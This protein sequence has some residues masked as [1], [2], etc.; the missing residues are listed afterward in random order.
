[1]KKRIIIIAICCIFLVSITFQLDGEEKKQ[2][3]GRKFLVEFSVG[4]SRTN[5]QDLFSRATGIGQMVTQYADYTGAGMAIDG[6]FSENKLMIP[7]NLSI[8]YPL[9]KK[10]YIRGGIEYGFGMSSSEKGFLLNWPPQSET[11]LGG[12]ESQ[13]YSLSYKTTYIMPQIGLGLRLNDSFDIYGTLGLGLTRFTYS[14]DFT[15]LVNAAQTLTTNLN[16][17]ANGTAPGII[18]GARYQFPIRKWGRKSNSSAFVKVEYMILKAGSLTG[19]KAQGTGFTVDEELKDATF[20]TF[21][22]NP[23]GLGTFDYWDASG[24]EPSGSDI[25]GVKKMSLN[26]SCIRLMIGISF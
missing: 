12:T 26:L 10:L 19:T 7:L 18:L 14:E 4:L 20:Y 3:K 6:K 22:W 8:V 23:F 13:Y 1:M 5:P 16:Y 11:D 17:T 24:T 25:G 9:N 15:V 2:K 21:M